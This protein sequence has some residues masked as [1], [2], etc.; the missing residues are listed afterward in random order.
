MKTPGRQGEKPS[1]G[2]INRT[3][4]VTRAPEK[5]PRLRDPE[6]PKKAGFFRAA[7]RPRLAPGAATKSWSK[8]LSKSWCE[9]FWFLD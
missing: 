7:R 5:I 4:Q 2:M 1:S 8:S 9:L 6:T 3:R